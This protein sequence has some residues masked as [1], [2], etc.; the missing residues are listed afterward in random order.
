MDHK[1]S[2]KLLYYIINHMVLS[3][4]MAYLYIILN[5]IAW[6]K[7]LFSFHNQ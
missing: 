1:I 4:P 2:M 3:I 6:L 5:S 7:E